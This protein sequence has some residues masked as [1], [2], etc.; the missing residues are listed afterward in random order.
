MA[1]VNRLIPGCTDRRSVFYANI[2]GALL[3]QRGRLTAEVSPDHLHFSETGYARLAPLLAAM[4]DN[5]AGRS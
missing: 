4:I 1:A 3:D 2:G 5:L